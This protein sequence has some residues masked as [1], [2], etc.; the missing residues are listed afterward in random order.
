M[1]LT[2]QGQCHCGAV[3][4]EATFPDGLTRTLRCNCSM[5]RRRGATMAPLPRENV[6]L[7][8][9]EDNLS[10]YQW[11]TRTAEHYFC[12]S[13]GIYTFHRRAADPS[14]YAVNVACLNEVDNLD[15]PEPE[16]VDGAS[17]P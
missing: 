5:C 7:L 14:Q 4:F 8:A 12:K 16:L 1:A 9:G 11:H 15:L 17:R 10:L 13:C 6:R 3:Q 2:C